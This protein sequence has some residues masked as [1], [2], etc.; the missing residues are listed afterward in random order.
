MMDGFE[1]MGMF[2]APLWGVVIPLGEFFGGL[3]LLLGLLTRWVALPFILQFGLL[4]VYVKPF[5]LD[6]WFAGARL[7]LAIC[8]F[9]ILLA[10]NG[11]GALSLDK[12][13]F[14]KN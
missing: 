10:T 9:A 5:L 6:G 12:L 1:K 14:K 13:L 2:W 7:D 11:A 8:V 3:A 4:F